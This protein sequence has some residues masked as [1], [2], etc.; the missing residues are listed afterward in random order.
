MYK[1]AAPSIILLA[2]CLAALMRAADSGSLVPAPASPQHSIADVQLHDLSYLKDLPSRLT[3]GGQIRGRFELPWGAGYASG[4]EDFYFA[5]RIR[6]DLGVRVTPWSRLFIQTQDSRLTGYETGARP[7]SM[8]N[9]LDVR[10][11]YVELGKAE[12]SG[13]RLRAGRQELN[14]G[15]GW[16]VSAADWG[17][18]SRVFDAAV[19]SA[20]FAGFRGDAFAGSV[21]L[22]DGGRLDR[23]KPGE[24][25]YG[26]YWSNT[27]LAAGSTLDAFLMAKTQSLVTGELGS[28]GQSTTYMGG[29]RA[30]GNLPWGLDYSALFAR[31]WGNYAS[32]GISA[33]GGFSIVG[34]TVKDSAW[35]PRLSAEI[36]LASGD[37]NARDGTRGTFDQCY[38]SFHDF[39]G[40]ADR[41]GWRNSRNLRAGFDFSVRRKMKVHADVRDLSLMT[42]QDGLYNASGT[43]DVF[44]A[45]AASRHVGVEFDSYFVYQLNAVTSFGA[46]FGHL[47]PGAYLN[48][49]TK[50]GAYTFPYIM[51]TRR[52]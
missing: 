3:L 45:K 4:A 41:L 48:D 36:D 20:T 1:K 30:L 7:A 10:Q 21:V 16:L 25:L 46:G 50:G 17:N 27:K 8:Q 43:R 29:G 32:D 49:S 5:S 13:V 34:W 14:Y 22:A 42:V 33:W 24:H 11:L 52:L 35:K 40:I 18:T 39:L 23:H 51:F 2:C 9:P 31:Q 37:R 44:N 19:M 15:G 47:L 38:G 12:G 6:L 28:R 26:T